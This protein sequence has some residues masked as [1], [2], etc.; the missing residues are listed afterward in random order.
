VQTI[1]VNLEAIV[2]GRGNSIVSKKG[3]TLCPVLF[4][5]MRDDFAVDETEAL[6]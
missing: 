2:P 4:E 3:A 6:G 5:A 1:F